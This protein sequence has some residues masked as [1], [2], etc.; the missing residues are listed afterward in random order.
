MRNLTFRLKL[1]AVLSVFL[2]GTSAFAAPPG[3]SRDSD[4]GK[5]L[6]SFNV[7]AV[8][9]DNWSTNDTTCTN[10][11]RRI[12]FQR[13][14]SGSIGSIL[15]TLDPTAN[16]NFQ[17]TDC[18]GT[19]DGTAA[20]LVNEQLSVYVMIRVVGKKT[21]SLNLTCADIIDVGTDD[22]CLIDSDTFNKG[23]SFTKIMSNVFDDA[24][25]EVLWTLDTTTGFRNAQVWVFE[26][27]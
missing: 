10:S 13:V 12:F 6:F 9:Q 22:L 24:L 14:Q 4:V 8:P 18:D 26:K 5:K 2:I 21:D 25:E 11:G 23:K 1:A 15:W 20:V 27:L 7:L 17:I 16:Q 3:D 19:S